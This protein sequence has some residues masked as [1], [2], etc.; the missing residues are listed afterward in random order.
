MRLER[1]KAKGLKIR[2]RQSTIGSFPLKTYSSFYAVQKKHTTNAF[3][4][5]PAGKLFLGALQEIS[6]KKTNALVLPD[7]PE[8]Q[9]KISPKPQPKIKSEQP[10]LH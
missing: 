1:T 6:R 2:R 7:T 9:E 4:K 8:Q 5:L 10:K 3:Q